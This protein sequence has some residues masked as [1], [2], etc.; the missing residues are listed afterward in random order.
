MITL[1]GLPLR[2]P[3]V[4]SRMAPHFPS[5]G[6]HSPLRRP[7]IRKIHRCTCQAVTTNHRGGT[8]ALPPARPVLLSATTHHTSGRGSKR[9]PSVITRAVRT[10]MGFA[11]ADGNRTRQPAR[12]RLTGFEDRGAHHAP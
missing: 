3:L 6:G 9:L 1:R 11:E 4:V 2:R 7:V 10:P 5:R 8:R 12:R